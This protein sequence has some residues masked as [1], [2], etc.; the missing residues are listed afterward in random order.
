MSRG[1]LLKISGH[2]VENGGSC[3]WSLARGFRRAN[4]SGGLLILGQ[5]GF[6]SHYLVT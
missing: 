4:F 2:S 1:K 5:V 3:L 6:S